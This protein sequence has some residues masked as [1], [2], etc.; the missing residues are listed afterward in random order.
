VKIHG[1]EISRVELMRHVGQLEQVAGVRLVELAD[2]AGRGTRVLEFRSGAG[3]AFEL[4]VD[5]A[6]DIGAASVDGRPLSWIS[7]V[8]VQGPWFREPINLGWLRGFGGGL[9]AT[10]GLDHTLLPETDHAAHLNYPAK[11]SE[12]Y[13]LHGRLS[14]EPAQLTGYG[15]RWEVDR[16][17]LWA[18]GLV[19]QVS[20]FG[21]NLELRRCIECEAGTNTLRLQDT[22][23]NRG[24][25][26]SSQMSLYHVNLGFPLI[27]AGS[28]LI[29]EAQSTIPRSDFNMD[30]WQIFGPPTDG[31]VEQVVEIRPKTK[32]GWAQATVISAVGDLLFHERFKVDTLPYLFLWRM[33][34]A[35]IYVIG[36]EP[37]TNSTAG[38]HVARKQNELCILAPGESRE[39][40]LELS[41]AS[42]VDRVADFLRRLQG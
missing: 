9:M 37:S 15:E 6:F 30:D 20:V 33:L 40:K 31:F 3:L 25:T 4:I 29:I 8:G 18:E 27:E 41:A 10:C 24:F 23:T 28:R 19:R 38:R 11:P 36:L 26:P 1:R 22:V 35:G 14:G 16:C 32:D 7:P 17:I 12:S 2:G 5:R 39:F 34:G 42:G 13:P 21:E